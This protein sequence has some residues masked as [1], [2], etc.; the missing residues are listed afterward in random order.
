M[1]DGWCNYSE[2]D[3]ELLRQELTALK[4]SYNVLAG[5]EEML[6]KGLMTENTKLLSQL[7]IVTQALEWYADRNHW[8]KHGTAFSVEAIPPVVDEGYRARQA[9]AKINGGEG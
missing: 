1:S 9:I 5:T 2:K 7:E 6:R 4:A 3:C 8:N